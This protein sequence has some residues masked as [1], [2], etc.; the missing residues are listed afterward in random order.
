MKSLSESIVNYYIKKE[1]IDA[2]KREVY[3]FGTWLIIND[4]ISFSVVLFVSAILNRFMYGVLFLV[5][6]YCSRVRCGGFHAK[7]VWICRLTMLVTFISV[8]L[9]SELIQLNGG[10]WSIIV[11]NIIS[12][13]LLL[14]I[15]PIENPNKKLSEKVREKNRREAI[16]ILLV[17]FFV[18]IILFSL[19]KQMGIIVA[20]TMLSVAVL[21][22]IGKIVNEAGGELNEEIS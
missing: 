17:L 6:F 15:I 4:I 22:V 3:Q 16:I 21:A 12:L 2:E 8:I 11:M 1:I 5:V 10:L 9:L 18:S 7:K 13:S 19:R 20:T 14:P